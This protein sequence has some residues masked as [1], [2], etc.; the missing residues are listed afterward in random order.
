M[1][2][3]ILEK[4]VI[5]LGCGFLS[6]VFWLIS[7]FVK[8]KKNPNVVKLLMGEGEKAVDLHNLVLTL[9]LQTKF[10][11]LAAFFAAVAI[12]GQIGGV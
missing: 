3:W 10:N 7:V 11:G 6:V 1:F 12:L 4:H 8:A 5:S 2:E 9:Q